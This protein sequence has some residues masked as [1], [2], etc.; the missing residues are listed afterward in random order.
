MNYLLNEALHPG[1]FQ[2]L[3]GLI[4]HEY[5]HKAAINCAKSGREKIV[6]VV[7]WWS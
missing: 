2:V 6:C 7:S 3:I 5:Q 4:Q 1:V